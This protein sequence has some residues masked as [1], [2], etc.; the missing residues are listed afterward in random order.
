LFATA[1]ALFAR[2]MGDLWQTLDAARILLQVGFVLVF[3]WVAA[4]TIDMALGYRMRP[5]PGDEGTQAWA[6]EPAGA[7]IG[8]R[9]PLGIVE[10]GTVLGLILTLFVAFVIFQLRY[11]FLPQDQLGYDLKTMTYSEYAREGFFQLLTVA[12]IVIS[13]MITLEFFTRRSRGLHHW[14]FNALTVALI[15]CTFVIL[16]SAFRRLQLYG[17]EHSFTHLRLYSHTFTVWLAVILV[18][19][20]VA[21]VLGRPRIFALGTFVALLIY[22]AALDVL[23]PDAF[24]AS[25]N[26]DHASIYG[27][28]LDRRNFVPLGEDAVPVM[29]ARLNELDPINRRAIEQLLYLQLT[30]SQPGRARLG[31]QSTNPVRNEALALLAPRAET[32]VLAC[33]DEAEPNPGRS[34]STTRSNP[35]RTNSLGS[36]ER[37][38]Q[39]INDLQ[40]LCYRPTVMSDR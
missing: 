40:P 22:L 6:V 24:I 27:K 21:V 13:L 20:L 14:L 1:D 11:L 3:A 30:Q 15:G 29:I 35:P 26:L 19:L 39:L 23:N 38:Q 32:L 18:L 7:S 37:Q 36:L 33:A 17:L 4:G 8:M 25:A 9:G 2:A 34:S 31:W 12:F 5:L 28:S 16:V 10:T